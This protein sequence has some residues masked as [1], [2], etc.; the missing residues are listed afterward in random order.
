MAVLYRIPPYRRESV[1]TKSRLSYHQNVDLGMLVD[2]DMLIDLD[3]LT[4]LNCSQR[5]SFDGMIVATL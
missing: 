3:M 1:T 4:D 2:L 5:I